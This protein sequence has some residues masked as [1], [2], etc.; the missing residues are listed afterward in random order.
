MRPSARTRDGVRSPHLV[1]DA[2][3]ADGVVCVAEDRV[4]QREIPACGHV[5]RIPLEETTEVGGGRG[6]IPA[7]PQEPARL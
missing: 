2:Q 1:E 4:E 6:D 7:H 5:G 3:L